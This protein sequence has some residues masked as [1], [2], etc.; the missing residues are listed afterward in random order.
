MN[1]RCAPF[2]PFFEVETIQSGTYP[3][4]TADKQVVNSSAVAYELAEHRLSH[5]EIWDGDQIIVPLAALIR[6][7]EVPNA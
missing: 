5:E 4:F 2:E 6:T 7:R 1:A 3:L